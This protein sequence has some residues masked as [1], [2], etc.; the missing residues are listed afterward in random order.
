[1]KKNNDDE[2]CNDF[3]LPTDVIE[4][5]PGNESRNVNFDSDESSDCMQVVQVAQYPIKKYSSTSNESGDMSN[6]KV[7]VKK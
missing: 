6:V 4:P 1:M 7:K 3:A 2:N 5:H